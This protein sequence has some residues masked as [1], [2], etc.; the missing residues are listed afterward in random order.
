MKN[1]ILS[2]SIRLLEKH[3]NS[4]IDNA[5]KIEGLS[6][7]ILESGRL[8]INTYLDQIKNK[9][10]NFNITKINKKIDKII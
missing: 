3:A 1:Q 6:N 2:H 4:I 7:N 5:Q 9:I 8:I 10:E